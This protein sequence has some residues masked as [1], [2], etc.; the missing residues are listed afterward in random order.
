MLKGK[1]D[2]ETYSPGGRFSLGRL[3]KGSGYYVGIVVESRMGDE[4]DIKDAKVGEDG[5]FG[6][7]DLWVLGE[8]I[9][10]D[11]QV[12]FDVRSL[13]SR[14]DFLNADHFLVEGEEGGY[15]KKAVR[16]KDH[17]ESS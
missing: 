6:L 2:K 17:R 12:A 15:A 8:P 5:G 13:S 9:F 14:G 1:R 3:A 11:V 10:Q 7:A 4:G 16:D